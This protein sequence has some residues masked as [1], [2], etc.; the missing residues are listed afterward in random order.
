MKKKN[1]III[2][3]FQDESVLNNFSLSDIIFR[4]IEKYG[5]SIKKLIFKKKY[6]KRFGEMMKLR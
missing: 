3:D 6:T 4:F 5:E 1:I 2:L